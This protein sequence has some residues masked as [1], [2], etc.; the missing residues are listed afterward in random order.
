MTV[1]LYSSSDVG[2]PVLTGEVGTLISV[3]DA[4]LVT[5]Y[6]AKAGAG[7]TKPF[8]TTN[9][10]VFRQSTSGHSGFYFRFDDAGSGTGGASE[11]FLRAYQTMSD[12]DTGTLPFPTVAQ[13]STGFVIKKTLASNSTARDWVVVADGGTFYLMCTQ[14]NSAT[15]NTGE[16]YAFGSITSFVTGDTKNVLATGKITQ[17]TVSTAHSSLQWIQASGTS[18][19]INSSRYLAERYDGSQSSPVVYGAMYPFFGSNNYIGGSGSVTTLADP[20]FATGKLLFSEVFVIESTST[21]NTTLRGKLRGLYSP[22]SNLPT[23]AHGD[24]FSVGADTYIIL[25]A[26]NSTAYVI[27]TNGT[28]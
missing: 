24:T 1:R 2:A 14:A 12:V 5:G 4:C 19:A 18:V 22:V 21:T 17:N 28:W 6:G 15:I 13:L 8:S 7:W 3:L 27:K 23:R 11:C 16:L 10:A 26:A 20:A 25:K 9:K